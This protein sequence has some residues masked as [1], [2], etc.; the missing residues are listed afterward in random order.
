MADPK[1]GTGKNQKVLGGDYTLMKIL[2]ILYQ[3]SLQ[4]LQMLAKL[5][6]KLKESVNH[7]QGK[8]KSSRL[9]SKEQKLWVRQ[10]WQAYL[11]KVKKR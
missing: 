5:C 6:Q 4:P 1:I 11:K 2:E 8:Y 3:L 9:V 7:T 10:R